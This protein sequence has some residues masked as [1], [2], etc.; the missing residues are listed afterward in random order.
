MSFSN[1]TSTGYDFYNDYL[2][3]RQSFTTK[4]GY[5]LNRKKVYIKP[6]SYKKSKHLSLIE[7]LCKRYYGH[8]IDYFITGFLEIPNFSIFDMIGKHE[9]ILER[10]YCDRIKRITGINYYIES[11][12]KKLRT[13]VDFD[14][15]NL[16]TMLLLPSSG[17]PEIMKY[18]LKHI[19]SYEFLVILNSIT[20]FLN[21]QSE[22]EDYGTEK[23]KIIVYRKYLKIN[24]ETKKIL[25]NDFIKVLRK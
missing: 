15:I 21:Q 7:S 19:I 11:E 1:A 2:G 10:A 8:H 23:S 25:I 3:I 13:L 16:E 14:I 9:M 18:K 20:K 24:N 22:D 5:E 6:E 12:I 4:K 17:I